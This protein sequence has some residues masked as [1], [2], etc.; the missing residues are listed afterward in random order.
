MTNNERYFLSRLNIGFEG[1]FSLELFGRQWKKDEL[2]EHVGSM[3]QLAGI[4]YSRLWGGTEDGVAVMLVRTGSGLNYQVLP[5]RGMDIGLCEYQ[6]VPLAWRSPTGY[7]HASFFESSGRG[8][9]RGFAG[10]LLTTCGFTYAG[11]PTV[12]GTE[13]L[14]LHGRASYTP[15]QKV[16]WDT[17]WKGDRYFLE[18]RGQ[19][20]ET[21]VFGP[22]L[23]LQRRICSELGSRTIYV[24]DTITNEGYQD[25]PHMFLYHLN[26]GFP[27]LSGESH[28]I[29][30]YSSVIPRDEE[31][32][33]GLSDFPKLIDPTV[34]DMDQ[35]FY[36]DTIPDADGMVTVKV[37]NGQLRNGQ[38]L[39][40]EISYLKSQLPELTIWRSLTRGRYVL[41]I[42]PG[43]CRVDGRDKERERGTLVTLKPGEQVSYSLCLRVTLGDDDLDRNVFPTLVNRDWVL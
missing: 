11:G 9:L 21:G 26:I 33:R 43:N 35:V 27:I 38:G 15:A 1:D 6:G 36:L 23:V 14:G 28:L 5:G 20:R 25:S 7:V 32:R 18:I 8:W 4:D 24:F 2:C 16:Q 41:G 3:E 12:D 10:G 39:G 31:S 19:V 22:N 34:E 37:S 13:Q 30:D 42:E 40:I 29:T 17:F